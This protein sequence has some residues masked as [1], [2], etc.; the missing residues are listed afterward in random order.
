MTWELYEV[1]AEDQDGH[2]ELVDTTKSLKE[3]TDLAKKTLCDNYTVA[4][5]NRETE[6]DYEEELKIFTKDDQ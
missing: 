4:W 2:Q 1:W 3:A 6:E 5:V